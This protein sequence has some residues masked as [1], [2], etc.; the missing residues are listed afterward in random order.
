[1]F[2]NYY[3]CR[4]VA[5]CAIGVILPTFAFADATIIEDTR[6]V[7]VDLSASTPGDE[8]VWGVMIPRSMPGSYFDPDIDWSVANGANTVFASAT[9]NQTSYFDNNVPTRSVD[10][11]VTFSSFTASGYA[12]A[13]YDSPFGVDYAAAQSYSES[14]CSI[15]FNISEPHAFTLTG[16]F[17]GSDLLYANGQISL[18]NI[19]TSSTEFSQTTLGSIN[20][21][22]ILEPG[23]YQFSVNAAAFCSFGEE[24][25]FRSE[26]MPNPGEYDSVWGS[27]ENIQFNLTPVPEPGTF[28]MVAV[29]GIGILRRRK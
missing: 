25:P 13:S 15:E 29:L 24:L 1:M 27:Y 14:F 5:I 17:D 22:G 26:A 8:A 6:K 11:P 23:N 21:T 28:A 2:R 10:L 16:N 9:V 18:M 7:E 12:F 19:D 4:L 20:G 3:L